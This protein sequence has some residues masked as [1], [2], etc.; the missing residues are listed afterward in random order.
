MALLASGIKEL[1]GL[2]R[3]NLNT[4]KLVRAIEEALR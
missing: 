3:R 2:S 1:P 4:Y